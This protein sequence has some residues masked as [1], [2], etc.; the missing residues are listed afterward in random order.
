MTRPGAEYDSVYKSVAA[1]ITAC[2]G[3]PDRMPFFTAKAKS[4][5]ATKGWIFTNTKTGKAVVESIV[6]TADDATA[7][8]AMNPPLKALGDRRVRVG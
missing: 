6:F 2:N 5:S 1:K 7:H 3:F 8:A 4:A